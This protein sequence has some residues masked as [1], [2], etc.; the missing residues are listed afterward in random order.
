M[1]DGFSDGFYNGTYICRGSTF[2]QGRAPGVRCAAGKLFRV[3]VDSFGRMIMKISWKRNAK[4]AVFAIG[5]AL[6]WPV[7]AYANETTFVSGTSVNGLGISNMT[8]EQATQRVADFYASDYKLTIREKGGKTEVITGPEIG[9]SVGLPEGYLQQ[10]LDEQNAS[11]RISGPDADNRHR[12]EM[13]GSFDS[14]ALEAKIERLNAISGSSIVTTADA[15]V[16]AYQEGQPFTVIPEVRGNN[17]DR[18]KT[19]QLIRDAAA[20]GEAEVDLE[21]A[22]CYDTPSVT[23]DDETLKTLCDTMNQCREMTVTYTFGEQSEGLD[24]ATICSWITGSAEG[25]IQL[26]MDKLRA[27]V[28]SLADKYDTAGTARTFHTADGRDVSVSGPFGWKIDQAAEADALAAVIRTAQSQ[29]REPLYASRAVDR[30]AAEWGTTYV[31]A[32]LTAQHVYMV[33]EGAVVWD[34]PCVT[35]NVSK[36]Y[37]TPPGLYSLT[38]KQRDRVL[39]GQKQADGKY[40]Y[41]TPV[42]YWMPFNGGIGF[43]D[44]NWRSKFGGTI[45]QT[46][47]SHGC[48]NLPPEKAAALY[49]LV[50]TGIPVICYN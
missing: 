33:K 15:H 1:L 34:A 8:V 26:D 35:G 47:G 25:Q 29:S 28:K 27:Y 44:A 46:S 10:I 43:H 22:G 50:Y 40:E 38:Y 6:L 11:G 12:T 42:S 3:C 17:V 32:D 41:E 4:S 48:V 45:Y 18:E 9:F 30:S 49:D 5:A 37:T 36:N 39:R 23:A 14:A 7:S 31:E 2:L 20:K 24:S 13:A 19:A 21:A 16:S